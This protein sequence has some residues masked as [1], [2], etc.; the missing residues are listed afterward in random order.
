MIAE[1]KRANTMANPAP[2]PTFSTNS[3]DGS[4]L[5]VAN[6]GG[7]SVSSFKVSNGALTAASGSPYAATGYN[8]PNGLA[9]L[10]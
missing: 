4:Y 8:N 10:N 6:G 2:D 1:I 7:A 9:S 5:F 3:T